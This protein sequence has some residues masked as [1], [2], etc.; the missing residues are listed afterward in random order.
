MYTTSTSQP[1]V[2]TTTTRIPFKDA[3]KLPNLDPADVYH[4][5]EQRKK[6]EQVGQQEQQVTKSPMT[7]SDIFNSLAEE[8]VAVA[9]NYQQNQG[10]D[11]QGNLIE[12]IAPSQ[13]SPF[14]MQP[15]YPLRPNLGQ[16]Q[17]HPQDASVE[18][19]GN[20][21]VSYQ[22]QQPNVM[23]YRPMPGQ[24]NNVV[25]S[26]GQQSASFVLGS[27]QQVGHSAHHGTIEKAPLF[28]KE[29]IAQVQYGQVINEDIGNIKRPQPTPPS[30]HQQMPNLQV[31]KQF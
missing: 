15:Q 26:P 29:P 3:T 9:N 18:S 21:Y 23:Q 7:L 12:P 22:V 11:A 28:P 16:K 5:L 30:S 14:A 2:F 4:T 10:F 31:N 1:V 25:I 27:Q 17:V 24:I 13:P 19:Y 6:E 20:E 8:E